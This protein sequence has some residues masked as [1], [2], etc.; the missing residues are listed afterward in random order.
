L[1]SPRVFGAFALRS[2]T[3]WDLRIAAGMQEKR[4]AVRMTRGDV[5]AH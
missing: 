5:T 2:L 4:G 3:A 1:H